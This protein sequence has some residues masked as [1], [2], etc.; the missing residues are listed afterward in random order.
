MSRRIST[1]LCVLVAFAVLAS[2]RGQQVG[3]PVTLRV[4]VPAKDAEL[5]I[6]G[7]KTKQKG[8]SR[9]FTS[10]PLEPGW[11]YSY[12]VTA[13]WETNNYTK[14]I[15]TKVVPLR[16]GTE[17]VVDLRKSDPKNPD[18][19]LIRYVP[20]PEIVVAGMC[21]LAGVKKGDVVFDLGCGDGRIVITAVKEFGAKRGVGVDIDP[22]RI[23][24]SAANA[25]EEK[26]SDKVKFRQGDVL[27]K[28]KDLGDASVVMLYMGKDVNLRL[29][30][31]LKKTLK[32]G[33][34]IVSHD[35]S[36]GDWKAEKTVIVEDEFGDE[37]I[38]YLWTIG[39]KDR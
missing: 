19:F 32:P 33:S 35:F 30:P 18:K 14:I 25:E 4:L 37:H 28:M 11:N 38:L 16:P 9:L 15:R 22:E 31:I 2:A 17:V 1:L 26:V 3:Q 10:P 24:E 29:M 6:E 39:K 12:T 20:T 36:M 13:T 7:K 23:L 27:Q 21:K 5:T 8:E 34:R